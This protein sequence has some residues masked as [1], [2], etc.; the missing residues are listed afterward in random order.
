[1]LFKKQEKELKD[2]LEIYKAQNRKLKNDIENLNELYKFEKN[3]N[4]QLKDINGEDF[5]DKFKFVI[6]LPKDEKTP[7]IYIDGTN[8][9]GFS[10]LYLTYKP[11]SEP[12]VEVD[13]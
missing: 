4:K 9:Q 10:R 11:D 3:Q 7:I 12:I 8:I 2:L 13:F 6:Y 5:K 1:M